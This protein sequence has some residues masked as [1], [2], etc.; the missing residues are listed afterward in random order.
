MIIIIITIIIII[1]IIMII[2]I[3]ILL[4]KVGMV[5]GPTPKPSHIS[6]WSPSQESGMAAPL[7]QPSQP[8]HPT[9]P[10]AWSHVL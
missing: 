10:H 9:I 3:I 1:I 4:L 7:Q 5:W 8:T 2:I 6:G